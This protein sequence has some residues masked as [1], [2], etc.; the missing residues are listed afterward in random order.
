MAA[1]VEF[2]LHKYLHRFFYGI[3]KKNIQTGLLDGRI[4]ISNIGLQ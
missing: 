2:I 1:I 3:D 4:T